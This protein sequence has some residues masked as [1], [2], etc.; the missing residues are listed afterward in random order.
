MKRPLLETALPLPESRP[1][2]SSSHSVEPY[3]RSISLARP[4]APFERSV[5]LSHM[6]SSWRIATTRDSSLPRHPVD[7]DPDRAGSY[8]SGRVQSPQA[9]TKGERMWNRTHL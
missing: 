3:R 9:E 8:C 7:R 6:A 2:L 5:A 1:A 4:P